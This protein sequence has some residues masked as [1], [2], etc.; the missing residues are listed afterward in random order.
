V[1]PVVDTRPDVGDRLLFQIDLAQEGLQ[2]SKL[3]LQPLGP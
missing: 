3:R 1:R 2:G